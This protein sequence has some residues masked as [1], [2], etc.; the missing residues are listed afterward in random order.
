MRMQKHFEETE[1]WYLLHCLVSSARDFSKLEIKV[2]DIRPSNIFI[3]EDGQIKVA[4]VLSWPDESTNFEK[5]AFEKMPTY[6]SPEEA[7]LI[8]EGKHDNLTNKVLSESFSIGITLLEAGLLWD[9]SQLYSPRFDRQ[10]LAKKLEE[11]NQLQ[12]VGE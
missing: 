11:W 5:T 4:N 6:L 7:D 1:L 2:G 3:N 10:K 9:V 12:F 8:A